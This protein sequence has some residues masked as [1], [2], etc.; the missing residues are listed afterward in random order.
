MTERVSPLLL[1]FLLLS[2][3]ACS[4]PRSRNMV[5]TGYCGC[6]QCCGWER[7]SWKYLKL[8]FWDRY[9]TDGPNAGKPYTGLTASGT[10]P[11]EPRPGLFSRD[12]LVHPWM[13]PVRLVFFPWLFLPRDGTVAADTDYLPFGTRLFVPGYGYGV[14]EDR[15]SAI[16][17]PNRLDLYFD[18]HQG[19]LNWGRRKVPVRIV[20]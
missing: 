14:V 12:S 9:V 15:G 4:A 17:G 11:H 7:G 2:L 18:S 6:S 1:A 8:D 16:Q 20:N 19:A 10:V 5:A 13:I 3:C